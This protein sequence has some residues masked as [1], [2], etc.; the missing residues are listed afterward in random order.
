MG[1]KI[2]SI[3]YKDVK[4]SYFIMKVFESTRK[5]EKESIMINDIFLDD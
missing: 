3:T 2:D 4:K 5:K 1:A